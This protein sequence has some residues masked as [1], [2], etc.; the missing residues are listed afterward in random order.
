MHLSLHVSGSSA[1]HHYIFATT[2][3]L[4]TVAPGRYGFEQLVVQRVARWRPEALH[5][6][7]AGYGAGANGVGAD[8]EATPFECQGSP[9]LFVGGQ[10]AE[11]RE[12]GVR[13]AELDELQAAQHGRVTVFRAPGSGVGSP[14]E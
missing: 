3:I 13:S 11:R 1:E 6:F 2:S 4:L 5:P 14:L 9:S 7:R 12:R 10:K 8:A